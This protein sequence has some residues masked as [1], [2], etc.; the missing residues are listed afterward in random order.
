LPATFLYRFDARLFPAAIDSLT[1]HGFQLERTTGKVATKYPYG[2]AL[3]EA[4]FWLAAHALQPQADG[5]SAAE[6]KSVNIAAV[7]FYTWGLLLL[8]SALRRLFE[9]G[10]VIV[11]LLALTFGTNLWHYAFYETGMSH[12]YSFLPL[13][14]SYGRS[15]TASRCLGRQQPPYAG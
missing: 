1:G 3:L 5:F 11:T 14:G 7:T 2:V 6:Q 8:Y 13:P 15:P 4:P 10:A 12:V 9:R